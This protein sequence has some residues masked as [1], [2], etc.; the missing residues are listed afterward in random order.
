MGKYT[1]T[2]TRSCGHESDS[3]EW[4]I[5]RWVCV[6]VSHPPR[7]LVYKALY[8]KCPLQVLTIRALTNFT[9]LDDHS[10]L[11]TYSFEMSLDM[12]A[13][14]KMV[15]EP[16]LDYLTWT[17][18]KVEDISNKILDMVGFKVHMHSPTIIA[19]N[20]LLSISK[21]FCH[22]PFGLCRYNLH[23]ILRAAS[24]CWKEER[25]LRGHH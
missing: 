3:E 5:V 14:A 13:A 21:V 22:S 2:T 15:D 8:K 10:H 9:L 7:K 16:N 19:T 24:L 4:D 17:P 1:K 18:D 23:T 25:V 20:R 6:S 11:Y 12:A